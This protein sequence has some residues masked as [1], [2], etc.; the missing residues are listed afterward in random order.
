MLAGCSQNTVAKALGNSKGVSAARREQIRELAQQLGYQPS[1]A[2]R[3]LRQ[4]RS[5]LIGVFGRLDSIRSM[6]LSHLMRQLHSPDHKP[7]LGLEEIDNPP[8]YA[9]P[10]VDTLMSLRVEAVVNF[11]RGYDTAVPPWASRTPVIFTG[12]DPVPHSPCD[13]VTMDRTGA[14]R[15]GIE[16]LVARGH[17]RIQML[18]HYPGTRIV[19]AYVQAV[20]AMGLDPSLFLYGKDE[21]RA[22]IATRFLDQF[23][24]PTHAP[25]AAFVLPTDFAC[26]L[27]ALAH[28]RGIAVPRQLTIVG[29]DMLPALDDLRIPITTLDQPVEELAIQTAQTVSRRLQAPKTPPMQIVCPFRLNVRQ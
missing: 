12:H 14:V 7:I 22:A 8:W 1:I 18:R 24:D 3:G 13:F 20:T 5:G 15:A 27:Y 6:M 28:G 16:Y 29:Y 2:A 11:S 17:R 10:W 21:T 23:D 9:T 19:N 4:G 25:T 26:E